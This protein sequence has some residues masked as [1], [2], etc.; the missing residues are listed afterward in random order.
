MA[1]VTNQDGNESTITCQTPSGEFASVRRDANSLLTT[2]AHMRRTL[3]EASLCDD[4]TL[5][6][7]VLE[8]QLV[9]KTRTTAKKALP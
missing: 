2:V 6:R 7:E 1:I 8:A 5:R 3:S 4:E 9:V